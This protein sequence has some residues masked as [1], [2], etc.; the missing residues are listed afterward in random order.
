MKII[1]INFR[2]PFPNLA[3]LPSLDSSDSYKE[4]I[5][6][7]LDKAVELKEAMKSCLSQGTVEYPSDTK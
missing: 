5:K 6:E 7:K 2:V 4:F 3:D 1:L